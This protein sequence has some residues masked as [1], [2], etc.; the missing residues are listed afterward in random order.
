MPPLRAAIEKE[1]LI[2]DPCLSQ[3]S[4]S[5]CRILCQAERKKHILPGLGQATPALLHLPRR[6]RKRRNSST[7]EHSLAFLSRISS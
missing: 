1:Q 5:I 6:V 3:T 4:T 2:S 7:S